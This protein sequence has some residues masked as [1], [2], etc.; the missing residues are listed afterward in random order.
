MNKWNIP[1][2][3]EKE[4]RARDEVCVFCKV[5]FTKSKK[6]KKHNASWEH[7]INDTSIINRY[8]IVLCCSGCNSS[9]G[10]K[11]LQE[12][13]KS[14]YCKNKNINLNT[15]S[16]IIREHYKIYCMGGNDEV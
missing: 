5:K 4:V 7:I 16:D 11:S 13:F 10:V 3:L 6:K 15:V 1:D 12:W 9:K 14:D 8:N 2:W